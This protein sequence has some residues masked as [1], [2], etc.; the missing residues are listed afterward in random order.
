[1]KGKLGHFLLIFR[2][3]PLFGS[4][5]P[6][7]FGDNDLFFVAIFILNNLPFGLVRFKLISLEPHH[8][9]LDS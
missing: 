7:F 2:A 9:W 8:T 3:N 5:I 4:K 6:L 1:M